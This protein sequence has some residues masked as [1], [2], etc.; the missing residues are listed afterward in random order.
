HDDTELFYID[1]REYRSKT[2]D[3]IEVSTAFYSTDFNEITFD[4]EVTNNSSDT[5]LVNP[6]EIY[7]RRSRD[8]VKIRKHH[9]PVYIIEPDARI[10]TFKHREE[11]ARK[12]GRTNSVFL[13]L[14]AI[15]ATTA[16]VASV[17]NGGNEEY[18]NLSADGLD[19][20][21]QSVESSK[22][23][24]CKY[25]KTKSKRE[26]YEKNAFYSIPIP[27]N[28]SYYGIIQL[29]TEYMPYFHL[30]VPIKDTLYHFKYKAY[31]RY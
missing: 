27:P 25:A 23:A 8:S 19:L 26:F 12:A 16:T 5:I 29:E 20:M 11:L 17:A 4:V 13:A 9:K 18:D 30:M 6:E 24:S 1:K 3:S 21:Q 14:G 31:G 22:R 28:Q 2:I 7:V 10:E 15:T